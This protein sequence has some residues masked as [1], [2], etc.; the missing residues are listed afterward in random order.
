MSTDIWVLSYEHLKGRPRSNDALSLL[1]KVASLV[2]P[3]MRS[4][5]WRLPVLAEFF[6]DSPNLIGLNINMGQNILLRL[7]PAWAPDT[8]YDEEDVI[9]TLLHEL[10]HNVHGPHDQNFYQFL[11]RLEEEYYELKRTG[12]AGEGFFTNGRRLGEGIPLNVPAYLARQRALEAAD[13][14]RRTNTETN[15][16]VRLGGGNL[17]SLG[18]TPR[19]LAILAADMRAADE[20]KC[21][22]GTLAQQEADRAAR[23]SHHNDA[24]DLTG[25]DDFDI[26]DIDFGDDIAIV[27]DAP[28]ASRP[29]EPSRDLSSGS[30][31]MTTRRPPDINASTRPQPPPVNNAS[32]PAAGSSW[33]CPTCT[34]INGPLALQCDACLATRPSRA[35]NPAVYVGWTCG[36]C[37][38]EGMEHDIRT[39]RFCGSVKPERT[40]G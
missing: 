8:F 1:K 14:R 38:E 22:S 28:H 15:G 17:A 21:A 13:R 2:K 27:S 39:C 16:P 33:T 31:P 26:D 9:Q 5:S 10:T 24:V 19:E 32:R 34:L 37:S 4:H 36:V 25:M 11:S 12:Y 3:I 7:R 20:K 29:T 18:L 40:F 23:D 30:G 35:P 6:P